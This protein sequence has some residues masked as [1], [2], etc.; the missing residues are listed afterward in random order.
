[1]LWTKICLILLLGLN[2]IHS[3]QYETPIKHFVVVMLENRAFDHILGHLK[4][5]NSNINGLSGHESNPSNPL[6][7][8]SRHIQVSFDAPDVCFC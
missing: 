1:M 3:Q 2:A 5:V 8:H 4:S 7:P 6:N